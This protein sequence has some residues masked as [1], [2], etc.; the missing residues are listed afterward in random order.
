MA[1]PANTIRTVNLPSGPASEVIGHRDDGS[2]NKTVVRTPLALLAQLIAGQLGLD[3]DSIEAQLAQLEANQGGGALAF[4]TRAN[5]FANLNFGPN[6][7]AT[8]YKDPNPAYNGVYSKVGASGT[9]SWSFL[10]ALVGSVARN[11]APFPRNNPEQ[12]TRF[13]NDSTPA[14]ITNTAL[15]SR[16]FTKGV[17]SAAG[18][19]L[20][21]G[22]LLDTTAGAIVFS[23]VLIGWGS[24]TSSTVATGYFIATSGLANSGFTLA[25]EEQIDSATAVYSG[26]VTVPND[27]AYIGLYLGTTQG[28][29]NTVV[30]GVQWASGLAENKTV[31]RSDYPDLGLSL[32]ERLTAALAITGPSIPMDWMVPSDLYL[33][34]GQPQ[35]LVVPNIFTTRGSGLDTT[36]TFG[37]TAP[38][39]AGGVTWLPQAITSRSEILLDPVR[40]P[41][42]ARLLTRHSSLRSNRRSYKPI[43]VHIAP[44]SGLAGRTLNG[45]VIGDSIPE[46]VGIIQATSRAFALANVTYNPIGTVDC[47]EADAIFGSTNPMKGEGRGS[48]KTSNYSYR[49]GV[50]ALTPCDP[51]A[52][53]GE[54]AYLA[55]STA[56]KRAKNP[57]LRATTSGDNPAWVF[58]GYIFDLAFYLQRFGLP[59]PDFIVFN[60]FTNNITQVGLPADSAGLL[61]DY[62]AMIGMCR[63]ALPNVP[64]GLVADPLPY[65]QTDDLRWTQQALAIK[66]LEQ[67]AAANTKVSLIP[68]HAF[69]SQ[70]EGW[71]LLDLSTDAVTGVVQSVITDDVHFRG[72]AKEKAGAVI[73]AWAAC[74]IIDDPTQVVATSGSGDGTGTP[75]YSFDASGDYSATPTT[76][77]HAPAFGTVSGVRIV[78]NSTST[79]LRVGFGG[80]IPSFASP[81]SSFP[82]GPGKLL[83]EDRV[84][85]GDISIVTDA[86]SA[87]VAV[88]F[89][90]TINADPNLPSA[91]AAHLARYTAT[92]DNTHSSALGTYYG[93]LRTAGIIKQA[94]RIWIGSAA[95]QADCLLDWSV[96]KAIFPTPTAPPT[97]G[98]AGATFDGNST[99]I[100]VGALAS[101]LLLKDNHTVLVG[102]ASTTSLGSGFTALGDTQIRVM[103]NRSAT[104]FAVNDMSAASVVTSGSG[105]LGGIFGVTR[106]DPKAIKAF[107]NGTTY[108]VTAAT[109]SDIDDTSDALSSVSPYIGGLHTVSGL[110]SPWNGLLDCVYIG[111][112]LTDAQVAA[113]VSA[114]ATFRSAIGV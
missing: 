17:T 14:A 97:F 10:R 62:A 50:D 101:N 66:L 78:N 30:A 46:F 77:V 100:D 32:A 6:T 4:D 82:I 48:R 57:F 90:T 11:E 109:Q 114:R 70:D 21:G 111:P 64:I 76:A 110:S 53:G 3:V 24:A 87:P 71:A 58:N 23:R 98:W 63:L 69:C 107:R 99:F 37:P 16:G 33:I 7:P 49:A 36:V 93:A 80:D 103:P 113:W 88:K 60:L 26:Y 54:A 91:I 44:L 22:D 13:F 45:I 1:D 56:D 52:V 5:L 8:V 72:D 41:T 84:I 29:A 73:A 86:G 106:T 102:T 105:S 108:P 27:Q 15:I 89:F 74:Q 96:N 83:A 67:V 34:E 38:R 20:Y 75:M 94:G 51:L 35:R 104:S 59:T 31:A 9:G 28:A 95:N 81:E 2:G 43:N 68:C 65:T 18:K 79:T 19:P 61:Q 42:S 92:L 12:A 40:V 85:Q 25:L 112:A 55:L 39:T 47:T